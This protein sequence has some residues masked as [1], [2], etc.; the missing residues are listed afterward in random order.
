V[1]E[2]LFHQSEP[3]QRRHIPRVEIKSFSERLASL[4]ELPASLENLAQRYKGVGQFRAQL[5]GTDGV[6]LGFVERVCRTRAFEQ[7]QQR[8]AELRMG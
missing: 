3:V 4:A 2:T 7:Q 6:P 8:L 5:S 1:I